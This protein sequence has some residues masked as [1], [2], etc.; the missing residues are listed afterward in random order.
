[1][2]VSVNRPSNV[3][4][5]FKFYSV[6]LVKLSRNFYAVHLPTKFYRHCGI[7]ILNILKH[8]LYFNKTT[9]RT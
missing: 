4:P 1:M 7:S 5:R 2:F 3:G 8:V 6:D 9:N